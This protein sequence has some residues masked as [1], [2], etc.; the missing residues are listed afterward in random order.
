MAQPAFLLSVATVQFYM[1]WKKE[2][3]GSRRE[4]I[5]DRNSEKPKSRRDNCRDGF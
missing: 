5:F 4:P 3:N 2:E 1:V